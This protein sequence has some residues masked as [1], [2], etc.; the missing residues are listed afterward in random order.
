MG[1]LDF[2]P[3]FQACHVQQHSRGGG[4]HMMCSRQLLLSIARFTMQLESACNVAVS[5]CMQAQAEHRRKYERRSSA[6]TRQDLGASLL[7]TP[8]DYTSTIITV[9]GIFRHSG[10]TVNHVT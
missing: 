7:A 9:M 10:P 3:R 4:F 2:N 5:P 1:T 6:L 8:H